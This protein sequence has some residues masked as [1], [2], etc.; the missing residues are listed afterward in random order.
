VKNTNL[1]I[2]AA[3]VQFRE[4]LMLNMEAT[5]FLLKNL[6]LLEGVKLSMEQTVIQY[7]LSR[8]NQLGIKDIFGVPG[9]YAFPIN[10]AISEDKNLR[11]IGNC[12]ELNA[13]YAADGYARVKGIAAVNTTYGVGELSAL[14][15]IAG[16]YA[17]NVPIFHLVGM[18]DM[19]VQLTHTV[20]HHTLDEGEFDLFYKMTE[21]VVCARAI[22]TPENCVAETERL[23]AEAI[24]HRRPVYMA[25][26]A[27]YANKPLLSRAEPLPAPQSDGQVLEDAVNAIV[28]AISKAKTACILPGILIAHFGLRNEATS[29]VDNSGLPFATMFMDKCVLNETHPAYI[30][31]YDAQLMNQEVRAFVESCDCV[32]GLGALLIDFDS[33]AFSSRIDHARS[34]SVMPHHVRVGD[35][36]YDNIEMKDVLQRLATRLPKRTDIKGPSMSGPGGPKG[37]ANDKITAEYLYPRW[38]Q[39]LKPNDLLISETGTSSMGLG[40]VRMPSGVSLLNQTLWGSIGWATPAAFGAALAAPNQRAVLITGEGSHQLTVQEICQ[41]ARYGLKPIIFVLNNSGY[42]IERLLCKDMDQEYNNLA[43]WNYHQ[44]PTA[45]GCKDWFTAKASTCGE[46]DQ[47]IARAETCGTGAYI[48]VITGRDVASLLSMKMHEVRETVHM[49]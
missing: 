9:D 13:A 35:V 7:V 21:P 45:L 49:K 39:F 27:N 4:K 46:L 29:V 28:G 38:G 16:A 8:L 31:M 11:W 19:P 18:P 32:L 5:N 25:F 40:F 33:G 34:I 30:G 24:Y 3:P 14:N 36:V 10:D 43:S 48:E 37:G 12:N 26:P 23:I 22:M 6:S 47:A 42:L 1:W 15:A 2:V 44:L 20:V 17:E 41:F